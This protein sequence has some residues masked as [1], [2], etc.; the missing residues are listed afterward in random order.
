M[1]EAN[2]HLNF[3]ERKTPRLRIDFGVNHQTIG[4]GAPGLTLTFEASLEGGDVAHH[5]GIA[6]LEQ[7]K[8]K[9]A[10]A[11]R[12]FQGKKRTRGVKREAQQF[13][14]AGIKKEE[15]AI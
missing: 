2:R 1:P 15:R 4:G 6:G 5:I 8:K 9:R 3:L 12:N 14:M 13:A 10:N 7:F 11:H